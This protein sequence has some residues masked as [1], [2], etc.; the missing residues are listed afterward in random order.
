[1]VV[2]VVVVVEVLLVVGGAVVV[3]GSIRPSGGM[4]LAGVHGVHGALV[5]AL[6]PVTKSTRLETVKSETLRSS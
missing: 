3:G 1:V 2:G 5:A 6:V 4:L